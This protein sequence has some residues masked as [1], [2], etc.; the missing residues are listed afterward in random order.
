[1]PTRTALGSLATLLAL[2][3]WLAAC[4]PAY[5]PTTDAQITA[6]QQ[7]T[8][9]LLVTLISLDQRIAQLAKLADPAS[10]K[11][12]AEARA[13]ASYEANMKA[14]D[15]IATDLTTLK[16]RMMATPDLAAGKLGQSIDALRANIEDL[17]G[18][19]AEQGWLGAAALKP[20]RIAINQQFETLLRYELNLKAGKPG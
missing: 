12:L 18:V 10:Q 6:A 7:E 19:H 5:D 13:A 15:R 1:V 16:L 2:L 17:Q 20:A 8:D 4:A 14:Y 3:A 11:A 9:A